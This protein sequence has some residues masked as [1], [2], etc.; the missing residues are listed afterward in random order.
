MLASTGLAEKFKISLDPIIEEFEMIAERLLDSKYG[1][2]G[3]PN[4]SVQ[5]HRI[6]SKTK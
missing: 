4:A 2:R 3:D 6:A 5:R 1:E